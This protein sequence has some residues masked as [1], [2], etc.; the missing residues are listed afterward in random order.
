MPDT[1]LAHYPAYDVIQREEVDGLLHITT[2]DKL[3][4]ATKHTRHYRAGSVVSYAI[5]SGK[6]PIKWID[7]ARERGE[8]LWWINALSVSITNWH[9]E[10]ET[11]IAI[12]VGQRVHFEGRTFRVLSAPNNNLTLQEEA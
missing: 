2:T 11:Y 12:R 10:R 7:R 8:R 1:I 3:A 9:R 4:L 6:C 5:E